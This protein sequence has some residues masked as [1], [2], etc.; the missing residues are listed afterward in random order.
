[1]DPSRSPGAAAARPSAR[2]RACADDSRTG[3]VHD[4]V[5]VG[6]GPFNLSL[7]AMADRVP[8]LRSVFLEAKP[9]FSWHPGLMIEGARMQVPFLADLVSLVDPT[10]PWSF[11]AYLGDRDRLFPFYFSEQWHLTRREYADYCLW[12]ADRLPNCRFDSPVKSVRWNAGRSVFEVEVPGREPYLARHLVLGVGTEPV[13]P[14]AFADLVNAAGPAVHSSE[15]L[16][17]PR[18][19]LTLARGT[20][21]G[22]GLRSLRDVTVVGSGQSGAEVFL[23]LLR[24]RGSDA[25]PHLRWITRTAALAPMEYSRLGLEHFTP[26]YTRYFH[27]LPEPTRDGLVSRQWQLYKAAS[28]ETLAAI[29]EA[30]YERTTAGGAAD[31][32]IVP[33]TEV[34]A[35][36]GGEGRASGQGGQGGEIGDGGI[37]GIGGIEL[38]CS[39]PQSGA[40]YA[41]R[42]DLVVLATGYAA[43]R[44]A[45]LDPVRD[46]VLWDAK[47]RYRVGLDHRVALRA[48]VSARLYVQNAEL[49]THGVGTPDLG[50]GAH[51]AAVILNA[52]CTEVLGHPVH[53]LPEATAW[54]TFGRPR[55]ALD[56]PADAAAHPAAR[57]VARAATR[58]ATDSAVR[59]TAH[60]RTADLADGTVHVAHLAAPESPAALVH[61]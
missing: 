13:I 9:E 2:P 8:D 22:G 35:A 14:R 19:P 45:L 6:L 17:S 7:A 53:R 54:T 26:D 12:A 25:G 33:G 31:V 41:L 15:Y 42:T 5:G 38:R 27:S 37:G 58:P 56:L 30:V 29:H 1:M 40:E 61:P 44:P 55:S 32:E 18:S 48:D 60:A 28:A 57:S 24:R 16:T 34:L 43:R 51:R 52:V 10:S 23:D 3:E 21:N 46:L 20:D 49:H 4:L 50:L 11:L 47:G 39:H 36:R 59:S